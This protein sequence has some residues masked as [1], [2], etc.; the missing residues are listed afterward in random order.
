[1]ALSTEQLKKYSRHVILPEIGL[2]GQE[3]LLSARVLI[4]GVGGLGS[5][6]ALYLAG[7]GVGTLG[8]ADFDVVDETNL[9]RQL[10]HSLRHIGELKVVSAKERI[11]S[12]N[13]DVQIRLHP[14]RLTKEN[15]RNVIRDYD[16]VVDGTDNFAVRYLL[17]DACY[18]ERKPLVYGSILRFDGQASVFKTPDGPCYRCLFPDP[19]PAGHIPSCSEAG[20]LGV[21]PGIIGT[22]QAAETLKLLLG[23]GEPLIGKLMVFD[24][25]EM[26]FRKVALEKDEAC[27][28]CG[29]NPLIR[30][31][32]EPEAPFCEETGPRLPLGI[33]V[34]ELKR[35][36]KTR[37]SG[38][39]FLDVREIYE[40]R[41]GRL[42]RSLSI[43]LRE[44]SER[45][46]EL[47]RSAEIV[48]VCQ[49]GGR[50]ARAVDILRSLGFV[51]TMNLIGGVD[52]WF[53]S[54]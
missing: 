36:R 31:L 52:A 26:S 35:L 43:P 16:V 6:A 32:V 21:V 41:N 53:L 7:A 8:L 11:E 23:I 46:G 51:K 13:A 9:Q 12:I 30:E 47:D 19:P 3:K 4:A 39:I 18:F 50:S 28:L 34:P 42:P 40:H 48:V 5:P 25:L 44:L 1:M 33:T 14:L 54:E 49:S 10:I 20:V 24:A 27:P 38:I 22:I 29:K 45:A 37:G 2:E 15:I 17:N